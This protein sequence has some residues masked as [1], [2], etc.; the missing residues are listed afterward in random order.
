MIPQQTFENYEI[1]GNNATKTAPDSAKYATGF[2]E[3]DVLPAEWMNW[4]WNKNT[5]GITDL[6][7]G[8][9]SMESE[10]GNVVTAGGA[11]PTKDTNNQV[12]TA[13]K[14]LIAQAKAQAILEAHPVG[15]LYWTSS[16]ENP[17][18]TFGGGT[19][20]Q[21]K[22]RFVLAAGSS[23]KQGNTGGS[24]TITLTTAQLPSHS[25]TI[26]HTHSFTPAGTIAAHTHSFTPAGTIAAHAHSFTPAGTIGAHTHSFTPAGTVSEHTHTFT[27][28]GS[29]SGHTHSFTP[30]GNVSSHTHSFTPAGTIAAHT[31]SFT[32]EGKI[33]I[34]AHTH[35]LNNHTHSFTPAGT[36]AAHT[37]SFTPAG[38]I[39]GGAYTFKGTAI[40][41][42]MGGT[43]DDYQS[44]FVCNNTTGDVVVPRTGCFS[45]SSQVNTKAL[46]HDGTWIS[47]MDYRVM[48]I[49]FSATPSGTITITTNPTFTGTAG[50]TGSTTTKFTGTAGTTEKA[51]GNTSSTTATGSFTGTAGNT[52]STTPTFTGTAGNTGSTTPTF[53]GTAGN[54]G[55]TTPTFTGTAGNTGST[56]PTFTGTEKET[57]GTAPDFTGTAGTTGSTTTKFTGTAGTTGSTTTKFTGT[58]GTT[59]GSSATNSGAVGSGSSINKMPPYI[60]EY[61]WTR[62]A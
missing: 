10:L 23:Y 15:S 30:K 54:T 57:A 56:T 1:F 35:T 29:I 4:A 26:A 20:T 31:H 39:S 6:N 47:R 18:V 16:T 3:S 55:S 17:A 38:I 22:D 36:I 34:N 12:I 60:V 45:T 7:A 24:A 14:Y 46:V 2:Q 28:E 8:V 27:P 53:T 40:S 9:T 50:T 42:T 52:G 58:A 37:H 44:G 59:G 62:T 21:I 51:S 41:G 11:T 25:H 49:R 33:T 43:T 5:K 32:P 48:E 13:I 61:C 19:W